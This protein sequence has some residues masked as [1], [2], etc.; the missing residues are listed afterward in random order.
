MYAASQL[1]TE[2]PVWTW[3]TSEAEQWKGAQEV[4]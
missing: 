1:L 3:K 2:G 4:I